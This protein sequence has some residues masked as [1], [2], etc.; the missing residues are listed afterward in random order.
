MKIFS[1][2]CLALLLVACSGDPHDTTV[3]TN[4]AKWSSSVKPS[5]QKLTPEERALFSQYAIRHT[6]GAANGHIGSKSDPI[7]EDMTI[8][9]AIAEQRNY[10]ARE[11]A[12]GAAH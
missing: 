4:I 5:L 2:L 10:L 12:K 8:G 1:I 9:K 11:Q 7:P 6:I 3:P